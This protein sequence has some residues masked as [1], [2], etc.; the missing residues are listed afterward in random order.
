MPTTVGF[1]A[2]ADSN[3]G[4]VFYPRVIKGI[5]FDVMFSC[6]L[7]VIVG[8]FFTIIFAY[9]VHLYNCAGRTAVALLQPPLFG[10]IW[11]GTGAQKNKSMRNCLKKRLLK[12]TVI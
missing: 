12:R 6:S 4:L 10:S 1:H 2:H 11:S 9:K 3:V 5:T 8:D 7:W